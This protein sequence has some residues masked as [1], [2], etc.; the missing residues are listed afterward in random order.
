MA[1]CM[2][3][4]SFALYASNELNMPPSKVHCSCV[5]FHSLST[6]G[7]QP[8]KYVDPGGPWRPIVPKESEWKVR[9]TKLLRIEWK[10]DGALGG[11]LFSKNECELCPRRD[12][13]ILRRNTCKPGVN[14]YRGV[15]VKEEGP[16][17]SEG[18]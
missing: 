6:I 12:T 10:E 2:T 9:V 1:E 7:S 4:S 5:C 14:A 11:L 16:R 15:Y 18:R 13:G 8:G 3:H 17:A